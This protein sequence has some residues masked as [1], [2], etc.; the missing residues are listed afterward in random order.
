MSESQSSG[1]ACPKGTPLGLCIITSPFEKGGLRGIYA[2]AFGEVSPRLSVGV[3][4]AR[5]F[6]DP[7]V[8]MEGALRLLS[9]V[10]QGFSPDDCHC[11]P[12]IGSGGEAI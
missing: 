2:L 9:C 5:L 6:E 11:D 8:L 4:R 1:R 12:P 7:P 3:D 10:T